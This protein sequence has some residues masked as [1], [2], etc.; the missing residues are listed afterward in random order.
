METSSSS[1]SHSCSVARLPRSHLCLEVICAA[2][3]SAGSR[4]YPTRG[5]AVGKQGVGICLLGLPR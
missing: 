2:T 3:I 5:P 1:S 4:A